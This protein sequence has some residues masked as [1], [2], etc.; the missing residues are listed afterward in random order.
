VS[1]SFAEL[2]EKILADTPIEIPTH[3]VL[4]ETCTD[5]LRCLLQI[6]PIQRITFEEFFAHPF[7]DLDHM[8]SSQSLPKAVGKI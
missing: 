3:M 2:K 7:V 6:N 5:L 1:N 4:S 8:P